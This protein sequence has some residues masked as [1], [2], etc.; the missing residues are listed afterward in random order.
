M[1]HVRPPAHV[2]GVLRPRD[3]EAALRQRPRHVQEEALHHRLPVGGVSPHVAQ[4]AGQLRVGGHG[5]VA[6]RVHG[7]VERTSLACAQLRLQH[8]AEERAAGEGEVAGE[9]GHLVG[10]QVLGAAAAERRDRHRGVDVVEEER[11]DA[12]AGQAV[13][14]PRPL[15]HVRSHQHGVGLARLGQR[16]GL[17]RVP[18]RVQVQRREAGVREVAVLAA[19]PGRI[20]LPEAHLVPPRGEGGEQRAVGGGV[21]VPPAGRQR[22]A[23]DDQLHAGSPTGARRTRS[24]SR[25]RRA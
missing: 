12:R 19:V 14:H 20:P 9:E 6:R 3:P 16:A 5:V 2:G 18:R 17:H 22:Q 1:P 15:V 21:A 8:F 23:E 13:D 25:A 11:L 24:S 7:A 4:L 10:P